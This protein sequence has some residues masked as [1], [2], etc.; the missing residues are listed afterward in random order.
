[1]VLA[2]ARFLP[3]RQFIWILSVRRALRHGGEE[4]VGAAEQQR[5]KRRAGVTAGLLCFLFALA[6]V[7]YLFKGM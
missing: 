7:N 1:M 6:Y 5:L 2:G 3:V 4:M